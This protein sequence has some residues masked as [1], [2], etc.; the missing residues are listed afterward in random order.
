MKEFIANAKIEINAS[1]SAVWNALVE[2]TIVKQYLFGTEMIADWKV[3]GSIIYKGQWN[4][5]N[6]E[7]KGKII[8]L[9][10]EKILVTTYWSSLSTLPDLPENYKTISYKIDK[11]KNSTILEIIQNNNKTE[12]E[13]NH[14]QDNWK[15]V[16]TKIKE[17]LEK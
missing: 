10:P 3:G 17:I 13:K 14:S 6:Y 1:P 4:G 8:K 2:P 9:V 16:L 5:K 11:N 12:E 7:D 15:L